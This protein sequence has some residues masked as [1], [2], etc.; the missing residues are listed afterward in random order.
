MDRNHPPPEPSAVIG[1]EGL[2]KTPHM[3]VDAIVHLHR[4][5]LLLRRGRQR[6]HVPMAKRAVE[7]R[8]PDVT[9]MREAGISRNLI[10]RKPGDPLARVNESHDFFSSAASEIEAEWHSPQTSMLGMLARAPVFTF[11][12]QSTQA[13]PFFSTWT[14]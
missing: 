4:E 13:I 2:K 8:D 5:K 3:A 12:W 6:G 7:L 11:L 9:L 10:N 14:L 1:T